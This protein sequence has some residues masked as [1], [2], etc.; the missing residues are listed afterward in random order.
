MVGPVV[1]LAA[2]VVLAVVVQVAAAVK[3]RFRQSRTVLKSGFA[4]NEAA[5]FVGAH[6]H[7][8]ACGL[9]I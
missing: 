5:F 6:L 7:S 8:P 9:L 1:D 3:Q 2:V 4:T